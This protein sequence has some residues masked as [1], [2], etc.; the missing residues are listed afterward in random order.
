MKYV[1]ISTS[2]VI[3]YIMM[4]IVDIPQGFS[5]PVVSV[6]GIIAFAMILIRLIKKKAYGLNLAIVFGVLAILVYLWQETQIP[7][8]AVGNSKA[9]LVVS[10]ILNLVGIIQG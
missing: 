9:I 5:I 4:G 8:S 3:I 2:L 10:V 1:G 6:M 7:V